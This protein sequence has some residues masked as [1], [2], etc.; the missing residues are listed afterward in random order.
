MPAPRETGFHS[1]SF[2]S[3]KATWP[4]VAS[5][6]LRGKNLRAFLT[7]SSAIDYWAPNLGLWLG[8]GSG[9]N[10]RQG[11]WRYEETDGTTRT[12]AM[13]ATCPLR[14]RLHRLRLE[15]ER[16]HSARWK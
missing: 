12:G 13:A 1:P 10:H 3:R 9:E 11:W 8:V 4:S 7:M 14:L 2:S 6:V 5:A 15:A 16:I